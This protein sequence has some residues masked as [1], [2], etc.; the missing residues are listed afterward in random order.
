MGEVVSSGD[1][2]GPG[3]APWRIPECLP[4][5]AHRGCWEVPQLV[6][7]CCGNK[8][9]DER[10]PMA[11]LE[12]Q[13]SLPLYV[14]PVP[15]DVTAGLHLPAALQQ[16]LPHVKFF[17]NLRL[18]ALAQNT[19][20]VAVTQTA[21]PVEFKGGL[22]V[23]SC[24]FPVGFPVSVGGNAHVPQ[25]PP[26]PVTVC[27]FTLPAGLGSSPRSREERWCIPRAPCPR[28]RTSVWWRGRWTLQKPNLTSV[29]T[30]RT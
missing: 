28:C 16:H 7:V 10:V 1:L 8:E 22:S 21:E 12:L 25:S 26:H 18:I 9:T 15:L 3:S 30:L 14:Y 24:E 13:E 4:L 2:L 5:P 19:P 20:H 27:V 6:T 23:T 11:A 17:I 29:S